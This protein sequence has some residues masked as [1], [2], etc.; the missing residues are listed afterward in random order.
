MSIDIPSSED[1]TELS[2][3]RNAG[4]VS[5]YIGS[6]TGDA[7][8]PIVHDTE[9]ARLALRST[10][11]DALSE[12]E[13][14]GVSREDRDD[15]SAGVEAL[16][17]DREFWGTQARTIAV[18][19]SPG[20][21]RAFR[22][23][24]ELPTHRAVG[25]RY[26]LGPLLRSTTFGHSGYVLAVTEGDVR[27]LF[28]GSDASSTPVELP[29]LP[30]AIAESLNKTIESGRFDRRS[31]DGTL[32]PKVEQ[33]AYCSA[34][35]DLVLNVIGDTGLPLVLSAAADLE[36]AYRE[37]NAYRGL[38]DDGIDANPTSLSLDELEKRG[39]AILARH[40]GS[41]LAT[42]RENFG[43]LRA[44][45]LASSQLSDVAHAATAGLVDTLLFDLSSTEEGSIDEGGVVTIADE[46]GPTTYGLVDEIAVRVLRLGGTVKAVRREDLPDDKPVAATFR[47]TP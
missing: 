3:Q 14:V 4:S 31:A 19:A 9:A 8:P 40:S 33:R 29:D 43:S 23:R 24:N 35:Q 30:E 22:L 47:G 15:I 20:H 6:G 28:L 42:W 13:T 41:E 37:V 38:L 26:D 10:L 44:N 16:E 7:R 21:I 34:V 25:D 2:Q 1:L 17:R 45:G 18:F 11:T 12:L 46:P 36:P 39:R 32:G 5:L 27:L